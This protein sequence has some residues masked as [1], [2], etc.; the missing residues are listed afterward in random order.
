MQKKLHQ[1]YRTLQD[2][3]LKALSSIYT[4]RC[5]SVEQIFTLH[6]SENA[7]TDSYC[8]QKMEYM[9]SKG[10][11]EK[12]VTNRHE[13]Y[14]LTTD[15]I[16]VVR[17][18]L[19]LPS[20]I[21]DANKKI[22]RRG[23]FRAGE[24]RMIPRN[25]NHQMALNQFFIDFHER[26]GS[27]IKYK[28]YD[29]KYITD[30]E[31]IRP[32]GLIQAFDID[33]FIEIDMST[34]S[35]G[36]LHEKWENYR[37]FLNSREY[38][39]KERKIIVLFVI[40]NTR[41]PQT[42]IDLTKNTINNRIMDLVDDNLDFIIDT[43]KNILDYLYNKYLYIKG[44]FIEPID[45]VRDIFENKGFRC[46]LGI[47]IQ[48]FVGGF[49]FAYYARILNKDKT[50]NIKDNKVQEYVIDSYHDKPYSIIKKIQS[51]KHANLAYREM[52]GRDLTYIV[53]A[54]YLEDIYHD[55]KIIDLLYIDNVVYT[56]IERLKKYP[57]PKA[58]V[59]LDAYGNVSHFGDYGLSKVIY[60]FNLEEA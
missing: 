57:L 9:V 12:E 45:T 55:L 20:N 38:K 11:L 47:N 7:Q 40:E 42:R 60:E 21:F 16:D 44:D 46:D 24:L 19:Q 25:I 59:T 23:Y 54:D 18:Y 1:I 29:E 41:V 26:L 43:R 48:R 56:T 4:H 52:L 27:K 10:L 15:G 5:M 33:F 49:N 17:E 51:L 28:Y 39:Y 53:V 22:I 3:E 50:I 34:E 31:D 36:Q 32:D 35:K 8:K 2:R 30:F 13:V 6:Y 14:F 37:R 58:L